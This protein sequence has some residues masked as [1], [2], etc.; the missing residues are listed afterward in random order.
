VS[1]YI[2]SFLDHCRTTVAFPL[3]SVFRKKDHEILVVSQNDTTL[4]M[5]Q[6]P[7]GRGGNDWDGCT[8]PW[9]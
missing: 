7:R 3:S 2:S 9:I 6:P 1:I 5:R 4:E 8:V